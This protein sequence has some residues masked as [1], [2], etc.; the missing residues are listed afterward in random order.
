MDLLANETGGVHYAATDGYQ[1]VNIY[2]TIAGQLRTTAGGNTSMVMN[3]GSITVDNSTISN[4]GSYLNY[5][6]VPQVSTFVDMFNTSPS[7]IKYEYPNYPYTRDDTTN[8]TQYKSFSYNIGTM[9]LNDTWMTSISFNLLQNGT[10]TLFGPN[11]GCSVSFTDAS[12]NTTTTAFIPSLLITVRN[13]T[14]ISGLNGPTLIVDNLSRIGSGSDPNLA[15]LQWNTTYTGTSASGTVGEWIYYRRSESASQWIASSAT[16]TPIPGPT[17]GYPGVLT[18]A[19]IDTST[20]VPGTYILEVYAK[21]NN[22]PDSFATISYTK[23]STTGGSYIK[24]E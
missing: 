14:I 7:G 24:L 6:Y 2:N 5:T 17:I 3:L 22:A 9:K 19:D 21:A 11:T 18:T 1:V 12:T 4:V 23:S 10:I 15:T 13:S 20:W 8:W 16:I